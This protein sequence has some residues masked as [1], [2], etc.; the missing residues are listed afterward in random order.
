VAGRL[1]N[2]LDRGHRGQPAPKCSFAASRGNRQ[3]GPRGCGSKGSDC[4][5]LSRSAACSP[6]SFIHC[7]SSIQ[8]ASADMIFV[9][10]ATRLAHSGLICSAAP[11]EAS[12]SAC[13]R[14]CSACRNASPRLPLNQPGPFSIGG[15]FSCGGARRAIAFLPI[16]SPIAPAA[17]RTTWFLFIRA[18]RLTRAKLRA[19]R[20][21]PHSDWPTDLHRARG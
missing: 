10:L 21:I 1:L 5:C 17:E 2:G 16:Q 4:S 20:S 14:S 6:A 15:A 3:S 13:L 11:R 19:I 12:A 18:S 7:S 8:P 9:P